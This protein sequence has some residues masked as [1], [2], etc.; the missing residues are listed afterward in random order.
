MAASAGGFDNA[1]LSQRALDRLGDDGDARIR[2]ACDMRAQQAAA[3]LG[4]HTEVAGRL[5]RLDRAEARPGIVTSA[6][7]SAVS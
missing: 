1:S 5:R 2:A 6:A 3:A 4:Q 7:G